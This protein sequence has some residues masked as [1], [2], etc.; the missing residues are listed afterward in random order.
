MPPLPP[1]NF[2][3]KFYDGC[4]KL[5]I[6]ALPIPHGLVRCPVQGPSAGEPNRFLGAIWRSIN[7]AID[8][9]HK[10]CSTGSGNWTL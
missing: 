6:N 4:A 3:V 8:D 10:L 7:D 2:A 1:T 9:A 5:G